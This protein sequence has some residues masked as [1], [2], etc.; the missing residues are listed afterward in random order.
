MYRRCRFGTRIECNA[1][2]AGNAAVQWRALYVRKVGAW[3]RF[4]RVPNAGNAGFGLCNRQNPCIVVRGVLYSSD[5]GEPNQHARPDYSTCQAHW[6]FL[7]YS[8]KVGK[9]KCKYRYLSS[10]K[11]LCW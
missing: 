1:G 2:N 4:S 6:A 8:G 3:V 11:G 9:W 7:L 5:K 10:R